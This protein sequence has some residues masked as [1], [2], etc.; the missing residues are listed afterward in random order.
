MGTRESR[1]ACGHLRPEA[2]LGFAHRV[3]VM[4]N[5]QEVIWKHYAHAFEQA[6]HATAV[7]MVDAI[8]E[9]RSGGLKKDSAG[10]K[11]PLGKAA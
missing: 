11:A 4:G 6:E 1:V 3:G 8:M 7:K 10:E 2:A 5:S 9:A